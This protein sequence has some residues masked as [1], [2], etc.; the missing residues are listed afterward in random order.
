MG[1]FGRKKKTFDHEI[2]FNLLSEN[3]FQEAL[4][5]FQLLPIEEWTE[6]NMMTIS[7]TANAFN[8]L[9][10]YAKARAAYEIMLSFKLTR[11]NKGLKM[12]VLGGIS[13]TYLDEKNYKKTLEYANLMLSIEPNDTMSSILKDQSLLM[14]KNEKI[15]GEAES[16]KS[17]D[18]S[19]S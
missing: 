3:K 5:Y 14:L 18:D 19:E 9:K 13:N 10:Q 16:K 2:G 15:L 11:N 6:E 1:L 7:G 17:F 8:G 12:T 4:E